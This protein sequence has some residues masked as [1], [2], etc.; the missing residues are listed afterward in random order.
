[1]KEGRVASVNGESVKGNGNG[2]DTPI[3]ILSARFKSLQPMDI[4]N[5]KTNIPEVN[6][7]FSAV[8]S[9]KNRISFLKC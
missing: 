4:L 9:R 7:Q 6:P 3:T 1:M 2:N 5:S 8:P